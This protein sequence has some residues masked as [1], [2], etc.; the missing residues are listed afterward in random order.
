MRLIL[1]EVK[2]TPCRLI[3]AKHA[4]DPSRVTGRGKYLHWTAWRSWRN[5]P[6]VGGLQ[7]LRLRARRRKRARGTLRTAR[8]PTRCFRGVGPRVRWPACPD[9]AIV[10]DHGRRL[11]SVANAPGGKARFPCRRGADGTWLAC[12][13]GRSGDTDHGPTRNRVLL[14][15]R[16]GVMHGEQLSALHENAAAFREEV[17]T[18]LAALGPRPG[19]RRRSRKQ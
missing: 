5:L 16:G 4:G 8:I 15:S 18:R 1:T 6:H 11:R 7:G 10:G 2:P 17:L 3:P 19:G 14:R 12:G 13:L 9:D